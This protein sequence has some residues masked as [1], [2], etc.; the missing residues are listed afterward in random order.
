MGRG[1]LL[2]FLLAETAAALCVEMIYRLTT[3]GAMEC[4]APGRAVQV[5]RK[6]WITDKYMYGIMTLNHLNL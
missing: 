6:G 1:R 4:P 2:Y 3:S 5:W